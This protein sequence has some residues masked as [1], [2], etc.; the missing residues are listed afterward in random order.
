MFFRFSLILFLL[1]T[2]V[3]GQN[4]IDSLLLKY[5]TK[6]IP[7]IAPTELKVLQHNKPF[8]LL[9]AREEDEYKVSHIKNA[10]HVGYNNFKLKDFKQKFQNLD[11]NIV[12]YCSVGI[13]SED[14]AYK[15]KRAGYTH[16]KNLYGGIFSWKEKGYSVVDSTNTPTDNIHTFSKA[17]SDYLKKGTKIYVP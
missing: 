3:Q 12:V 11:T 10:L 13:R 9:D 6:K 15:L 14:I 16:V 5:N 7:Y 1:C 4:S 2:T 17:W 8:V